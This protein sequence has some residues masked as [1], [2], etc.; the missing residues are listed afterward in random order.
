MILE[1][2]S[3]AMNRVLKKRILTLEDINK[4]AATQP[5]AFMQREKRAVF[6]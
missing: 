3:P 4:Q 6:R 2:G 5:A 1:K